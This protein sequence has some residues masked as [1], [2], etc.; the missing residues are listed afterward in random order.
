MRYALPELP[1]FTAV[2]PTGGKLHLLRPCLEDL[3]ERTDYPNLDIL[4]VDNSGGV[5]VERLVAELLPRFPNL[6]RVVDDTKPF[7]YPTLVNAGVSLVSTPYTLEMIV[8]ADQ[9]L[10]ESIESNNY[11]RQIWR[12]LLT[13]ASV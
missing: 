8:D 5:N 9:Q 7:N 13:T 12:A 2:I 4:L 11:V 1:G 3:L 6:R 10:G